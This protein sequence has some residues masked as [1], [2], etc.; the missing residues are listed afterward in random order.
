MSERDEFEAAF[1]QTLSTSAGANGLLEYIRSCRVDDEY[2][3]TQSDMSTGMA[4]A[5]WWAWRERGRLIAAAT[6]PTSE[7]PHVLH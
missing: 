1:V 4:N 2:Y 6:A 5:A 7:V 3:L